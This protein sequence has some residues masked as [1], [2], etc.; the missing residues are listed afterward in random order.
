MKV[1]ELKAGDHFVQDRHGESIR[2]EVLA[3]E[4]VG[5]QFQVSFQSRLGQGSARYFGNAYLPGT[6]AANRTVN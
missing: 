4:C 2:F 5:R 1:Q 6:R 3:V